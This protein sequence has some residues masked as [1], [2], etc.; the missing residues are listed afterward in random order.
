VP[1]EQLALVEML[2]I[3]AHAVRRADLDKGENVLVIGAGPI[4]MG[5]AQFARLAGANVTMMD[6]NVDRLAFCEEV[7][8]FEHTI[9]ARQTPRESL[10]SIFDGDLPTAVFDATG[11]SA[12]MH[13]S[14]E[15]GA[16]GSKLIFVGLFKGDISFN[17][18]Y[19]HSHEMSIL[20]SRN[21][22]DEDFDRVIEALRNQDIILDGWITHRA[23]PEQLLK[24]FPGWLQ[25]ETGVIKA[26]LEF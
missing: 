8:K 6:I 23:T 11:S 24:D 17:D 3:G 7:L 1:V 22:T 19:F 21:A 12:S 15:Y 9:E 16:H 10:L 18:P 14:F 25:A 20:A 26:M 2:S 4:G 13:K 5:T